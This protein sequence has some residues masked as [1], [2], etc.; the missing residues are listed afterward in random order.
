MVPVVF[1]LGG[2]GAVSVEG[3]SP[4]ALGKKGKAYPVKCSA[5]ITFTAAGPATLILDVRGG[6]DDM[7]KPLEVDITRNE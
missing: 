6:T 7:G 2:A 4:V 5:P 3:S 1:A